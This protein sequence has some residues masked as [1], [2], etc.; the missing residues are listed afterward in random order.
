MQGVDNTYDPS[1]YLD[2]TATPSTVLESSQSANLPDRVDAAGSPADA[3][4]LINSEIAERGLSPR[5]VA[6]AIRAAP[7]MT[8]DAKLL[9]Y[10]E[11]NTGKIPGPAV[12]LGQD[13]RLT[14][15]GAAQEG[16]NYSAQIAVAKQFAAAAGQPVNVLLPE[17]ARGHV[18]VSP[19]GSEEEKTPS[20]FTRYRPLQ[21]ATE[22]VYVFPRS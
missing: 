6:E 22:S 8:P 20:F 3:R 18:V 7:H 2:K 21:P 13:G 4:A 1:L 11:P 16:D 9:S 10:V 17:G 19:D 12:F 15:Y 14:V 5:V